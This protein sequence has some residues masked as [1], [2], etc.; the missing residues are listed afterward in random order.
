MN[1]V[2][3]FF[4][5]CFTNKIT[6]LHAIKGPVRFANGRDRLGKQRLLQNIG[7]CQDKKNKKHEHS[8]NYVG[9]K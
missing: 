7:E 9:I 4:I 3:A 5:F 1:G 8:T 6:L 2:I